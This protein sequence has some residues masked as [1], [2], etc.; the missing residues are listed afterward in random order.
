[1]P[2]K[3]GKVVYNNEKK[4]GCFKRFLPSLLLVL[5]VVI[6]GV[7][8]FIYQL[9]YADYS[10]LEKYT[11]LID[12]LEQ[13]CTDQ[14]MTE[15]AVGEQDVLDFKQLVLLFIQTKDGSEIFD[16][17]NNFIKE[18]LN[19]ENIEFL[20]NELVLNK[21]NL[22]VFLNCLLKAGLVEELYEEGESLL[23]VLEITNLKTENG[24]TKISAIT[25]LKVGA[26]FDNL[27]KEEK[28]ILKVLDGLPKNL[29]FVY[30]AIFSNFNALSSSM[31]INKLTKESNSLLLQILFGNEN[32]KNNE[33]LNK[34]LNSFI[35]FVLSK[36]QNYTDETG[37]TFEFEGENLIIKAPV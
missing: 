5:F 19:K 25:K 21:R 16:E 9:M 14:T 30:D 31:Q 33:T 32:D 11:K 29:Y 20:Q 6:F 2:F 24:K 35:E 4:K 37:M 10:H 7:L 17:N 28:Q 13:P 8:S 23:S 22:A 36:M 15:T 27:S 18:N 3:N 34:N 26:L 1:M 12:E